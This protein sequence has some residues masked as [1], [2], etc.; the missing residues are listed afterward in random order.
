ME[1]GI[2][3]TIDLGPLTVEQLAQL[4]A[5]LSQSGQWRKNTAIRVEINRRDA[6]DPEIVAKFLEAWGQVSMGA[7]ISW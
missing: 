1:E 5:I 6:R 7:Q 3:L 4:T 2:T